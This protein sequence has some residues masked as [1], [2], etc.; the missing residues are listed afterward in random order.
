MSLTAR[1]TGGG[2]DFAPCPS[3]THVAR[4]CWLIDLGVQ[5]SELY[6]AR[7][8]VL[9]GWELPTELIQEG[10]R[11]GEPFFISQFYTMSLHEKAKLR[12][13][14]EAWR[15]KQFTEEELDG[16]DLRNILGK[17]CVLTVVHKQQGEKIRARVGGVS[18]MLKGMDCP[19]Q[20]NPNRVVDF[21]DLESGD[22]ADLPEWVRDVIDKGIH[23]D[24]YKAQ[25]L[26]APVAAAEDA[27]Y[28]LTDPP[29]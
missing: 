17:P 15:D 10:D 28:D 12:E 25:Q 4:C 27:G 13:H 21:D 29:F 18:S 22:Y 7:H 19:P 16:F 9:L 20:V 1:A 14:L 3:G 5:E 11:A 23:P 26:N 2:G 6:G 8:K 24:A